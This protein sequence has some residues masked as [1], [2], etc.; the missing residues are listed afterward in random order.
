[1]IYIISPY[2]SLDTGPSYDI[3]API[4]ITNIFVADAIPQ[5]DAF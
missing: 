4:D 5:S 1:M 2:S 3:L